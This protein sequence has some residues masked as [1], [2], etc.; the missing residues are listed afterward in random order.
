VDVVQEITSEYDFCIVQSL[1]LDLSDQ[2]AAGYVLALLT[3]AVAGAI[4]H[5]V[6]ERFIRTPFSM[7][8]GSDAE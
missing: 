6:W 7:K 3:G 4:A 2:L 1:C 8:A 5:Y